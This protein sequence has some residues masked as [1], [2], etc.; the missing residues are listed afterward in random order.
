MTT[1]AYADPP[2]AHA[3]LC[4]EDEIAR[5]VHAF[6]A[7]VRADPVLGPIF[8]ARIHDWDAHLVK[9]VD[10]W[11][12]GLRHTRRFTGA[13]MPKHAAMPGL[14][15]EL[16]HRWLRLFRDV[17]AA[18]SNRAMAERAVML[19]ERIAQ[20]LWLGYQLAHAPDAL[21]EPLAHG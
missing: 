18:Q 12:S 1:P 16:F 6:Y 21:P 14:S 4:T 11:S 10:F 19:A 3:D 2:S 13:P 8:D 15:A 5:L 17:A 7:R 9:L 20:S